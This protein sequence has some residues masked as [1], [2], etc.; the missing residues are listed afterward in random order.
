MDL[1][2]TA[3]DTSF[4]YRGFTAHQTLGTY[5]RLLDRFHLSTKVGYFPAPTG[6]VHSLHPVM[7]RVTLEQVVRDLGRPPDLVFLHNPE[8]TL[9]DDRD[10]ETTWANACDVLAAA[11]AAG[12][13]GSWGVATWNPRPLLDLAGAA[14][15]PHTLMVRAGLL[16]G[17][18]TL[19]AGETLAARWNLRPQ[20]LWGMSPFGGST[21]DPVWS[22]VDPRLLLPADGQALTL[23]QAAFRLAFELPTVSC[24]AVGAQRPQHLAD[25]LAALD[26]PVDP[27]VVRDYR[28]LLDARQQPTTV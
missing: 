14:P 13:C 23:A 2:V 12:L 4:N 3:I 5:G 8:A 19:T 6:P 18:R 11:V 26:H 1:G 7:L 22:A 10:A 17:A 15:P 9:S 25:L 27:A 20:Q 24:V 16:V 21:T 28:A